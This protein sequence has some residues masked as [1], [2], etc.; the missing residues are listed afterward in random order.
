MNEFLYATAVTLGFV[1]VSLAIL[2]GFFWLMTIL[3][4]PA[5]MTACG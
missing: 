2:Y 1:V 5:W 3:P 4:W